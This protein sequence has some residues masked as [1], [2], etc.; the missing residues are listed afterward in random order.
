MAMAH[1]EQL[2]KERGQLKLFEDDAIE[3]IDKLARS[4]QAKQ[5][6][7]LDV[8]LKNI[9]E[10]KRITTGIHQVFGQIFDRIGYNKIP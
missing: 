10:E 2:I 6:E 4:S 3:A 5:P 8:N 7:R 1:K 9:V